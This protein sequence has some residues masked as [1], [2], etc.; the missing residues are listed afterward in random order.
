MSPR[1]RI[2]CIETVLAWLVLAWGVQ[3]QKPPSPSPNP[4]SAPTP[5]PPSS[6]SSNPGQPTNPYPSLDPTMRPTGD[7]VL[8]LRGTVATNDGTPLPHDVLVERVCNARV[9]QQVYAAPN[10]SFSMEL[11]SKV[12]VLVDASAD[13]AA[14]DDVFGRRNS[15]MGIPRTE[16]ANCELRASLSGFHSEIVTLMARDSFAGSMD[17]GS[18]MVQRLI[19]IEDMTISA[20]PYKAPKDARKAYE[21]GLEAQKGDNLAL[22]QQSFEKA[23]KIYPKFANAWFQLGNVLRRKNESVA[24]RAAYATASR[25]DTKFLP[26]YLALSSL[27][28][29]A[30]EW[31][32][33]LKLTSHIL[34]QDPLNYSRV[35]GYILDL[36]SFDYAEAYFYHAVANFNLNNLEVAERS[37]LK[38]ANLD[39]RP[40]FPQIHLLL[41]EI[42]A[43]KNDAPR[44]IAEFQIYLDQ[45]PEA[46]N[47]EDVR[48]RLLSLQA[49]VNPLAPVPRSPN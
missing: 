47:A 41:G 44:A 29:S 38:A 39:V 26:P 31:E 8:F 33:V 18:I 4:P 21:K 30:K 22:A 15:E 46:R 5:V 49:S 17:V 1:T 12:N 40:R 48:A 37:A 24:A 32:E 6:P 28:Y 20:T 25:I 14:R 43:R 34:E 7:L 23:V 13:G 19:K 3:A 9:R 36:D 10:G 42:F 11:G 27:A 16:L 2:I 45:L 35:K